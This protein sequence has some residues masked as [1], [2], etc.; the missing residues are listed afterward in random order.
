MTSIARRAGAKLL[1]TI[2]GVLDP[3][4]EA[5][6]ALLY[7]KRV[8][9]APQFF[10][11]SPDFP[12][13]ISGN[14][15]NFWDKPLVP[16]AYDDEFDSTT[17]S[18]SWTRFSSTGAGWSQGGIN[19]YAS[20]TSGDAR[21]E[22]HTQRRP[23]WLM[24]QPPNDGGFV[25]LRKTIAP[26]GDFF[27]WI[28]ASINLRASTTAVSESALQLQISTNPF[29]ANN[30]VYVKMGPDTATNTNFVRFYRV[31]GG[32]SLQISNTANEYAPPNGMQPI[33]AIGITRR[34]TSF[35]AWAF[36]GSGTSIWLGTT[37]LAIT[38]G[39]I[40]IDFITTE[41][42]SPGNRICGVDFF[43]YRDGGTWLP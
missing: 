27:A 42:T 13:Q 16:S 39:T 33:E 31:Q 40:A 11:R 28:R 30:R 36:G 20:F 18:P 37:T 8:G 2:A 10:I 17:L 14:G 5:D 12:R 22:L 26:A 9:D 35:D 3:A 24:V 21:Y 41:D 43:R 38:P 7:A 23:S 32:S 15:C 29:D 34:G 4:A 19:P 6:R 1:Q 25:S